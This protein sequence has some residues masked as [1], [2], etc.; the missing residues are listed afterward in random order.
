MKAFYKAPVQVLGWYEILQ[1]DPT[2]VLIPAPMFKS[3]YPPNVGTHISE[4]HMVCRISPTYGAFR[5]G[6]RDSSVEYPN[7]MLVI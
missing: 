6:V 2:P 4:S 5:L 3:Q 7:T 1:K